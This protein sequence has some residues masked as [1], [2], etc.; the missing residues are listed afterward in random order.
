MSFTFGASTFIAPRETV[1]DELLTWDR[2]GEWMPGFVALEV[3][4]PGRDTDH[5]GA[6]WRETRKVMGREGTEEFELVAVDR[7]RSFRIRVDG[8]KGSTGKGEYVFDYT[9]SPERDGTRVALRGEIA[10]PGF[11]ARIMGRLFIGVF[12]SACL[13]DLEA[14]GRWVERRDAA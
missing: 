1:Y 14:F 9:L 10:I 8:S 4:S 6:R 3:L 12:K 13:K 7:P 11:F 5:L 2:M